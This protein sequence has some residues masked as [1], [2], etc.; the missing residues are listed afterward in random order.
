MHNG[1]INDFSHVKRHLRRLLDDDIY[2]WIQGD[3]DSEH[4]FALF[5]QMAKDRDLTEVSAVAQLTRD[6][7]HQVHELT[8]QYGLR[9]NSALNVCITD[10]HR[11]VATRYCTDRRFKPETLHYSI[12]DRFILK[13]NR[14]QMIKESGIPKCVL[15]SSERLNDFSDEWHT[16][17]PHHLLIID[18]NLEMHC[19]AL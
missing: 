7:F 18:S 6:V 4:L 8:M 12:G 17:P 13:D 2:N 3:T 16:V 1:D 19:S 10:G 15:I 14:Y 5:L 11:L 9:G